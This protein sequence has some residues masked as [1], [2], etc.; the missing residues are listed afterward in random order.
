MGEGETLGPSSARC[1]EAPI[2]PA[3]GGKRYSGSV[4]ANRRELSSNQ[5]N[6]YPSPGLP[7]RNARSLRIP[8]KSPRHSEMMSPVCA[9]PAAESRGYG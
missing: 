2:D 1:C 8:T 3:P 6:G 4:S 5:K 7:Q 9:K